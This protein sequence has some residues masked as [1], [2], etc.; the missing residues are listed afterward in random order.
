[1]TSFLASAH[2]LCGWFIPKFVLIL[3]GSF[4]PSSGSAI[5]RSMLQSS[6]FTTVMVPGLSACVPWRFLPTVAS[7]CV[8]TQTS[9]IPLTDGTS[10]L[11]YTELSKPRGRMTDATVPVSGLDG[12]V[13][14]AMVP[15]VSPSTRNIQTSLLF[16]VSGAGGR[17][18]FHVFWV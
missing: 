11:M 7:N 8:F 12:A 16:V 4:V 5:L 2:I 3:C 18:T 1:M 6:A 14:S 15:T 10:A 13:N 17:F 9:P